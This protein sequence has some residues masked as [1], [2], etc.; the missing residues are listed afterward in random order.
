VARRLHVRRQSAH[1]WQ[2]RWRQGGVAALRS[3]G[4]AGPKPK[5]SAGQREGLAAALVEGPQAHS[6]VTA[7]WTLP[8][9]AS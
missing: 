1:D 5:L 4:A 9:V 6:Y 3:R 7:V 8:R 2:Q